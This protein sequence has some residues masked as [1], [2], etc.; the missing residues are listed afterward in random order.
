MSDT[1]AG[2]MMQIPMFR[3]KV[4]DELG[5]IGKGA[6]IPTL[7]RA[8]DGLTYVIK[9]DSGGTGQTVRA[10]EFIWAS[11]ATAIALPCVLAE[12]IETRTG[13]L[14]VGTRYES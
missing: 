2:L 13:E 6:T 9:D 11:V 7:I 4:L 10:S 14:A 3:K 5:R 8:D 12:V 1:A